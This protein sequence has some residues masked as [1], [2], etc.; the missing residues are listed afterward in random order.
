MLIADLNTFE[1]FKAQVDSVFSED[2]LVR[3]WEISGASG[4]SCWGGEASRYIVEAPE[5]PGDETLVQILELMFPTL[6]FL[7]YARLVR[8]PLYI[9]TNP[10]FSE[11]YGNYVEYEQ[12]EL[13]LNEL[14][15]G[16]R[17]IWAKRLEN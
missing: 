9:K 5:I 12:H 2:D 14:Y 8:S 16:L 1:S 11:Y 10:S 3:R 13:D 17:E 6:T 7:E 15:I 4:G